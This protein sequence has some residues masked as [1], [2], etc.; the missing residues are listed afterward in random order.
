MSATAA[1]AARGQRD[2]R[3]GRGHRSLVVLTCF[4][5]P[6]KV[7]RAERAPIA[8]CRDCYR[9]LDRAFCARLAAQ[10]IRPDPTDRRWSRAWNDL[11][12][13]IRVGDTDYIRE[14]LAEGR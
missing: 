5:C 12:E 6:A 4:G 7:R 8:L 10:D 2:L 14:L 13:R 3:Y 11:S 9:R 1:L